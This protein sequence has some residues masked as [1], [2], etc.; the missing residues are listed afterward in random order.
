MEF[1]KQFTPIHTY[2]LFS[3]VISTK[4]TNIRRCT[5]FAVKK[6]P[7]LDQEEV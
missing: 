3:N 4:N 1:K 5:T 7:Q 2:D 6:K